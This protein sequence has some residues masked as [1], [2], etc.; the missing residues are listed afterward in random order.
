MDPGSPLPPD[1]YAALGVDKTTDPNVIKS[2][3]RKL[4]LRCH[5]DKV[6]DESQKAAKAEEFHRIQQAYEILG[7]E[8]KRSRYDA[9]V[10]LASLRREA[11]ERG[12]SGGRAAAS[13]GSYNVRTAAPSE[14]GFSAKGAPRYEE[15]R[16]SRAYDAED[17][18]Y[19]DRARYKKYDTYEAAHASQRRTPPSKREAEKA[20]ARETDRARAERRAR[21]DKEEKRGRDEKYSAVDPAEERAKYEAAY[22]KRE[23]EVEKYRQDQQARWAAED[24]RAKAEAESNRRAEEAAR[25]KSRMADD[26]HDD[27][28][29]K[30]FTR[31][32]SA[33]DYIQRSRGE[34]RPGMP[35]TDS[36]AR[37]QSY[38][39]VRSSRKASD[40]AEPVR[41]SSARPKMENE[42]PDSA[43]REKKSRDAYER[44]GLRGF[45]SSPA[46]LHTM[47]GE[48]TP[49]Y[50]TA[51]AGYRPDPPPAAS[52]RRADTM[53]TV[54]T[55]N[56]SALRSKDASSGKP[57]VRTA[58]NAPH[59]S[60]YSSQDSPEAQ[61][62][63]FPT[64]SSSSK[65]YRYTPGQGVQL[66]SNYRTV[67]REPGR[68]RRSPSPGEEQ[69]R[70][71]VRPPMPSAQTMPSV[72][73]DRE[74]SDR[75]MPMP[76]IPRS[77]TYHQYS[78]AEPKVETRRP[79]MART[80]SLRHSP[81]AA[82]YSPSREAQRARE[83]EPRSSKTEKSSKLYG[84]LDSEY[85][86]KA[87]QTSY[88]P[89][90][91]IFSP[92]ITPDD[93]QYAAPRE[94]GRT[95]ERS[96]RNHVQSQDQD[97]FARPPMGR[98]ATFAY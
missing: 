43:S 16:P 32:S 56:Q 26:M 2:T 83:R 84:E 22:R 64:P 85:H 30:M 92:V 8:E 18:L 3:Y 59:D 35:R 74:S 94:R 63:P 39:D 57:K 81:A 93:V 53:P 96:G 55:A 75:A 46:D 24:A 97:Y 33:K 51:D 20:A 48:K 27:H 71:S 66:D 38:Y 54:H 52:M 15:R 82:T 87:Q 28:K 13:G 49:R 23:E 89:E 10:R 34:A 72:S 67:L 78:S 95:R 21:R 70:P 91:I 7:D 73:R 60:G 31:E 45:D 5:P 40:R 14:S 98:A 37:D 68:Q 65:A 1:P 6:T 58:D 50:A 61:Y 41:R 76:S 36:S 77:S 80:D 4:A 44:P 42:R 62:P 19:E 9:Q 86:R 25:Y 88:S 17:R 47:A 12:G 79:G 90:N 11:M 29:R 69:Y